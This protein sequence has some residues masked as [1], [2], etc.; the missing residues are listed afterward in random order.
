MTLHDYKM[1]CPNYSLFTKN[2]I[3]ERCY[4]HKYYQAVRYKCLQDSY[5][6][7]GLAA[8]EMS[9][10]KARQI[11]ENVIDCFVSPSSF[12]SQ[13]IS[14][15]GVKTRRLVRLPNFLFLDEF[16]PDFEPGGYYLYFGSLG[17]EKGLAEL[18]T[19][20]GH[21]SG[22]RLV[23]A[24]RGPLEESLE[25]TCRERGINNIDFVGYKSGDELVD[26]IRKSR[27]VIAPSLMYDNYPYSV[28]EA[29]ALGKPVI[30]TRRGGIPEMV[31]DAENGYLY[32]PGNPFALKARIEDLEK[33][34]ENFSRFG[35]AGR[36]RAEKENASDIHYDKLMAIYE[37][38]K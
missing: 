34:P 4:R 21:L 13:K 32:E 36:R 19:V 10:T 14:D 17:P 12:F 24:G 11:Y 33:E 16:Q 5:L 22:Y 7:S 8:L 1:I 28:L 23:I 25:Q 29:Q 9:Y 31:K 30:A 27:A 6:A 18:L 35:M 37:S 38:L 2:E 20:F 26:L 3:C 15:W